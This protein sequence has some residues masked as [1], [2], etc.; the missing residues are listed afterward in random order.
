M[1]RRSRPVAALGAAALLGC[2]SAAAA[3]ETTLI[4]ATTNPPTAH[5]NARVLHPWAAR[6]N[7]AGK[8]VV[9]LDVRDGPQLV[10]SRN[11]YSRVV[12]DVVQVSWGS[13]NNVAGKFP[14]TEETQ[15]DAILRLGGSRRRSPSSTSTRRS[16]AAPLTARSSSGRVRAPSQRSGSLLRMNEVCFSVT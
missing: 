14:L 12:D 5:L 8:G 15:G 3:E 9:K 10:N 6:I 1:R 7:E 4:F 16:S 13:P 11:H 2:L